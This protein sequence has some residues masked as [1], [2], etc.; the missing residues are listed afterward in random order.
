LRKIIAKEVEGFEILGHDSGRAM[1][2]LP[3]M[4]S[5]RRG[6]SRLYFLCALFSVLL[7]FCFSQGAAN[8]GKQKYGELIDT[9]SRKHGIDAKLVH[10]IISA[11]SA[12][13]PDAVSAKGAAGLMQLMPQTAEDYGVK[14]IFDPAENIE[15]GVKYLKDLK[16]NYGDDLK[17]LLAAYNAGEEAVKK[18]G[19]IPPYP[20]TKK[21]IK[22]IMSSLNTPSPKSRTRIY[23]FYDSSGR[24]VLTNDFRYYQ[25][26][27]A[28][29]N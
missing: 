1:K 21:Y 25:F 3:A 5:V 4:F 8:G 9:I 11:E 19:D 29:G 14:N 13:K 20:E 22:K 23:K 2:V 7:F 16:V 18:Y 10:S 17:L 15:G 27:S 24:L 28:A 12:Y 6:R 26:H